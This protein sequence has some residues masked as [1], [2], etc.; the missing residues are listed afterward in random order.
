M[1]TNG[2]IVIAGGSGFLGRILSQWYQD[3]D[4]DVVVLSRNPGAQSFARTVAWDGKTLEPWATELEG[5]AA[6]INLAGRSV[7]CRYHKANRKA[8]M[9]SRIKSTR[10]LGEAVRRCAAPPVVWLN[11]STATI[12]KHTFGEPHDEEHGVIGA[13]PQAKDAFSIEVATAWEREFEQTQSPR[14]RKLLLRSAMVLDSAPG[15]VFHVLQRLVRFGLGGKMAGGNQWMSWIHSV[16]FCRVI[17]WLIERSDTQGIYNLC[18]PHPVTNR[19]MMATLRKALGRKLGFPAY[20]WML[21]VGAFF[22]RTETE[23][24]IKSRRVVPARLLA[25]GFDFHCETIGRAVNRC[26]T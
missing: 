14:T 4:V 21:E 8:M 13:T 16:D 7:N 25:D 9:D 17:D 10:V 3:K 22:L 23:L 12:Y 20:R 15:G 6:L 5:A 18:A 11:S 24:M 2:K 1:N 26:L 19:D